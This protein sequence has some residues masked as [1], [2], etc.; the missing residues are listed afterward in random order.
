MD[1]YP[2]YNYTVFG[3]FIDLESFEDELAALLERHTYR[4]DDVGRWTFG[5]P[6]KVTHDN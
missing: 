6:V 2:G 4:H 5:G 3:E 1:E